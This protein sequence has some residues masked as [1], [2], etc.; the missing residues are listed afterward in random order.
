MTNEAEEAWRRAGA[1]FGDLAK[2]FRDHYDEAAAD[3]EAD[4]ETVKEA[5]HTLGTALDKAF[6]S[7]GTALR[8]PDIQ[9]EAR[10]AAQSLFAALSATVGDLGR[11]VQGTFSSDPEDEGD[12]PA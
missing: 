1:E 12:I 7:I 11:S 9:E 8:D 2:R 6:N 10:T 4:T 5:L 3:G